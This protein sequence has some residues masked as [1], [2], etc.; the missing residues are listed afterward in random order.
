MLQEPARHFRS[1]D[2][3]HAR[4]H[5]LLVALLVFAVLFGGWL[6]IRRYRDLRTPLPGV[7]VAVGRCTLW[8]VGSSTI[9]RWSALEEDMRPWPAVNRGIYGAGIGY[10]HRRM[11][12]EPA[13]RHPAA[14]VFYGGD[15]DIAGGQ[16][17]ADAFAETEALLADARRLFGPV[18]LFLLS[19]KPS[20]AR[21]ANFPAQSAYNARLAKYARDHANTTF[22]NTVPSLLRDGRPGSFYDADGIHLDAA[23]YAV[24]RARLIQQMRRQL[25]P[26]LVKTCRE[27]VNPL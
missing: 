14:I 6:A 8:F 13:G 11:L 15:N 16:S 2:G 22:V 21:W 3:A 26:D 27:P 23:G 7:D 24:V 19:L 4:G 5:K 20:P 1:A 18:P 17:A 12:N 25:A 9:Q 10:I